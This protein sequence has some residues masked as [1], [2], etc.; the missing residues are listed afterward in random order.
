MDTDD[1]LDSY[2][3]MIQ[4]SHSETHCKDIIWNISALHW[5]TSPLAQLQLLFSMKKANLCS[6][7]KIYLIGE[8]DFNRISSYTLMFHLACSV[9]SISTWLCEPDSLY[10]CPPGSVREENWTQCHMAIWIKA[11]STHLPSQGWISATHWTF[12]HCHGR[13]CTCP[14]LLPTQTHAHTCRSHAMP[15][16][17]MIFKSVKYEFFVLYSVCYYSVC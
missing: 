3:D 15:H 14:Q 2:T 12:C 5:L 13:A 16:M 9:Y 17:Q 11:M 4:C 10:L 8:D 6:P 7:H 1:L